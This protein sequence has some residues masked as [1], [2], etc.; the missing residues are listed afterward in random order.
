MG[1]DKRLVRVDGMPLL[2]LA[3][4]KVRSVCDEIILAGSATDATGVTVVEDCPTLSGPAAGITAGL[5]AVSS[6]HALVLACDMPFITE[7]I[8]KHLLGSRRQGSLAAVPRIRGRW[9]P[10][11]AVYSKPCAQALRGVCTRERA[12]L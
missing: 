10:L 12:A 4:S 11:C 9:E 8:L 1:Q 6:P 2:D 5:E 7:A 3:L